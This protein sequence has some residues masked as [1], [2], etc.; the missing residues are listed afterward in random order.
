[1]NLRLSPARENELQF[2]MIGD[3]PMMRETLQRLNDTGLKVLDVEVLW[4]K[5]DTV[6]SSYDGVF[7]AAQKLGARQIICAGQDPDLAR[8]TDTYA[9]LCE[10]ARPYSLR[11]DL[12]FMVISEVKTLEQAQAVV[13][14]AAQPNSGILV[15]ALHIN[16]AGSSIAPIAGIDRAQLPFMQLCDAPAQAPANRDGL[17][18]EARHD[19]L[20]PGEGGLPLRDLM[21]VLPPDID[22]S[23]EAPL[24]GARGKLPPAQRAALLHDAAVRFLHG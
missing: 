13:A 14:K 18:Q 10:R 7:E 24:G 19:R 5:P 22:I 1:V 9:R 6:P 12:E 3:T 23:V 17:V 16:R 15:D 20:P 11:V 8:A 2:P 4:L 21:A